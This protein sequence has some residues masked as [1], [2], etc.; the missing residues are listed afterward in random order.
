MK[1]NTYFKWG[2]TAFL[3]ICASILFWL[4]LF[5]YNRIL[6]VGTKIFF[7]LRPVVFGLVLA[8]I[9]NPLM[10]VYDKIFS[11]FRK[12][13]S[14]RMLSV[15][16]AVI[17]GIAIVTLLIN[18]VIPQVVESVASIIRNMPYQLTKAAAYLNEKISGD[19]I[20]AV[21]LRNAVEYAQQ[22]LPTFAQ[23][24]IMPMVNDMA[25]V[26]VLSATGVITVF[27][28][29]IIGLII[30]VYLLA[31]KEKFLKQIKFILKTFLSKRKFRIVMEVAEKSNEVFYGF[32]TGM[33]LDSAIVGCICC[34]VMLILKVPYAVLVSVI[35]GCTNIIPVF[36]PFIGTIPCTL[37]ILME[38]PVKAL[39]FVIFILIM[40]QIDGNIISPRILG[41]STGLS[42][43]WV[44]FAILVFGGIFG[45]VGMIIGVPTMSVIYYVVDKWIKNRALKKARA[46]LSSN[47]IILGDSEES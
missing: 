34:I 6:G 40:Q 13:G 44:M 20:T 3:V 30:A 37:I 22:Y 15:A 47:R 35:I 36:G 25:N 4:L 23:D 17:T 31:G 11:G 9:L 19:S 24:K 41:N 5:E 1:K 28:D 27:K 42:A 33:I 2:L 7:I 16:M 38:S 46:E 10:A 14:V 21:A 43:F 29:I 39:Y 18:L 12:S 26:I 32:I 8:Y 45:F